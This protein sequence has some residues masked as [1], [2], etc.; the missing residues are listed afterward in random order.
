MPLDVYAVLAAEVH[1]PKERIG[2]L[3]LNGV[4][5]RVFEGH[6]LGKILRAFLSDILCV[7]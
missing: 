2:D 3:V 5:D 7:L 6:L 1:Q 4:F